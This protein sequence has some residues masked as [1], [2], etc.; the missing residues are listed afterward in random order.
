MRSSSRGE[1]QLGEVARGGAQP[2]H[3]GGGVQPVSDDVPHEQRDT[4]AGERDDVEPVAAHPGFGGQVAVR[5][6]HGALLGHAVRQQAPLKGQC[7]GVLA[8]VPA[9]V[10]DAEGG[11]GGE[12]PGQPAVVVPE[13]RG[14]RDR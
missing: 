9:G 2:A 11:A 13:G 12:L 8:G 6:L 7:Q 10:V 3:G 1:F 4:G 5:D 14:S